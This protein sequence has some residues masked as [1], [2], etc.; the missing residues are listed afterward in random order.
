MIALD[1]SGKVGSSGGTATLSYTVGV[2]NPSVMIISISRS[3]GLGITDLTAPTFNGLTAT[4]LQYVDDGSA[5]CSVWYINNPTQTTANVVCTSSFS[6]FEMFVA[7]YSG[8]GMMSSTNFVS[9]SGGTAT[10]ISDTLLTQRNNSWIGIA[11]VNGGGNQTV[12]TGTTIRQSNN[13][14]FQS[15]GL[16][17]SNGPINPAASTTMGWNWDSGP[18]HYGIIMFELFAPYSVTVGDISTNAENFTAGRRLSVT[19][20]DTSTNTDTSSAHRVAAASGNDVSVSADAGSSSVIF[21]PAFRNTPKNLSTWIDETKHS[22]T[23]ETSFLLTQDGFHLLLQSFNSILLENL[24]PTD[25][26]W[27]NQVKH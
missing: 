14:G 24:T 11:V 3:S 27:T 26:G 25:S 10:A 17:D 20:G 19:V 23:I 9:N 5:E 18:Q 4:L 6:E 1:T 8:V 16:G 22:P 2:A 12:G 13:N 15:G 21:G 7:T